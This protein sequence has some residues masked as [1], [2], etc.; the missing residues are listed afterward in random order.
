L[1][2]DSGQQL[3]S[4]IEQTL[5]ELLGGKAVHGYFQSEMQGA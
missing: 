4:F 1:L 5:S 2:G 3:P